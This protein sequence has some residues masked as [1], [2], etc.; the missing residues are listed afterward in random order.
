[1]QRDLA[2]ALGPLVDVVDLRLLD[3]HAADEDRVG[4][5]EIL[6]G[7]AAQVLVDE[8]HLPFFAAGRPR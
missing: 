5:G 7:G 6:V 3:V 1:M 4:P 8:A 2:V